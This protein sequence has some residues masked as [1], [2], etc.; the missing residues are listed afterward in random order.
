MRTGSGPLGRVLSRFEIIVNASPADWPSSEKWIRKTGEP[1]PAGWTGHHGSENPRK[2]NQKLPSIRSDQS[3]WIL[4]NDPKLIRKHKTHHDIHPWSVFQ[5]FRIRIW[6]SR[7]LSVGLYQPT[8]SGYPE[9]LYPVS[10]LHPS[11]P[12]GRIR[13]VIS[14]QPVSVLRQLAF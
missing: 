1:T 8:G 4:E 6:F 12:A 10:R 7:S 13:S 5:H 11:G 3:E 9:I 2:L 14:R